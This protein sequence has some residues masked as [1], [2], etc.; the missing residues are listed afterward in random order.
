MMRSGPQKLSALVLQLID[1]I[2]KLH[3]N[4]LSWNVK[5]NV[6]YTSSPTPIGGGGEVG[7][8]GGLVG[9]E[10]DERLRKS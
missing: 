1:V 3:N 8:G 2:Q 7:G 6:G 10:D 9:R 4:N 5:K